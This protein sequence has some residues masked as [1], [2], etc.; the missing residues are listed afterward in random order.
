MFDFPVNK[1]CCAILPPKEIVSDRK[2]E[3]IDMKTSEISIL[4]KQSATT[5]KRLT[6]C[7]FL[8]TYFLYLYSKIE[9]Q[10]HYYPLLSETCNKASTTLM[11]HHGRCLLSHPEAIQLHESLNSL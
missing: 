10:L 6:P 4:T 8:N 5:N 2:Y 11:S 7:P 9:T 1:I 3:F